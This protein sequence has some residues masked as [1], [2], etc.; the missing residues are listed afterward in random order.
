MVKSLI[1][2]IISF[3]IVIFGG[4]F[5]QNFLSSSFSEMSDVFSSLDHDLKSH[6]ATK[7]EALEAQLKWI[8]KKEYLHSFI[9]HNDIKEIDLW[10]AETVAYVTDGNYD[11]ARKKTIVILEL[12][13]QTP[14]IYSLRIENIL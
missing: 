6:T 10:V 14:K 12:L 7:S 4:I 2:V 1:S 5:E 9:P 8:E 3:L 13:E 11:E